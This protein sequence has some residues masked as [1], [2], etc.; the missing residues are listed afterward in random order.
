MQIQMNYRRTYLCMLIVSVFLLAVAVQFV[1]AQAQDEPVPSPTPELTTEV[2]QTCGECH[3]DVAVNWE[4]SAHSQT[5]HT[6]AFRSAIDDGIDAACYACHTTGF[7]PFD[8]NYTHEGVACEACHGDTPEDHPDEPIIVLPGLDV[9][10]SCHVPTYQ[11]WQRSAHGNAEMPCTSCHDPHTQA[12]RFETVQELCLN[13]HEE[14]R[15]DYA[16]VTHET[17]MCSD[18]HWHRG[19][20]D[21]ETHLLTGDLG[22]SGH[23]AQVETLAC[24]DCHSNLDE[25]IAVA[26]ASIV[27]GPELSLITQELETEIANVRAQGENEAAVRLVQGIVVGIAG[28]AILAFLFVRLSPG[29]RVREQNDDA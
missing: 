9:C 11:E 8:G 1:N 5:F 24:I 14:A 10:A 2:A 6:D 13:C 3:I 29:Q 12:M 27:S 19:T 17:E 7:T 25:S 23:D 20:F 22:S 15:T 16:H 21:T 4:A 18:C 26:D 28:G